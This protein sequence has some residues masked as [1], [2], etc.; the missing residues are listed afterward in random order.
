MIK[1]VDWSPLNKQQTILYKLS[2]KPENNI[3]DIWINYLL[4]M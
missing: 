3:N 1:F 4:G 2:E